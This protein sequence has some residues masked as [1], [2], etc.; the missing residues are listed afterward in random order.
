MEALIKMTWHKPEKKLFVPLLKDLCRE[1]DVL[2]VNVALAFNPGTISVQDMN[3]A[4]E[5]ITK[6]TQSKENRK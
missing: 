2:P 3:W 1:G 4:D 6:H 5:L